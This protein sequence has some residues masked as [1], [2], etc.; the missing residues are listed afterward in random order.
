MSVEFEVKKF[1]LQSLLEKAFMVV[2]TKDVMPILKNFLFR[3]EAPDKIVVISTD[4]ALTMVAQTTMAKVSSSAQVVFPGAKLLDIVRSAEDDV[5]F[6]KIDGQSAE[7]KCA[8]S[9]I[10]LRLM[11][12][13]EYPLIPDVDLVVFTEINRQEFL[14]AVSRVS[15]VAPSDTYRPQLNMISLANGKVQASDGVRFHQADVPYP[16]KLQIPAKAMTDLVKFLK[17]TEDE[18][19]R[20]GE[21]P[22]HV[23]FKFGTEIFIALKPNVDFPPL[24]VELLQPAILTNDQCCT[25]D[26]QQLID[27]IRRVRVAADTETNLVHIDLK[28]SSMTLRARDRNGNYAT[29]DMEVVWSY[30]YRQLGVNW[31]L[32]L[33]TLHA[34]VSPTVSFYLGMD[35]KAKLSSLLI[36][37]TGFMAVL[38]QMRVKE[39][40]QQKAVK[41]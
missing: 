2:P 8:K 29:Q 21:T 14:A 23:V 20:L 38:S 4:Q 33:T 18:F 34:I 16:G 35:T 9:V 32:L 27:G 7:I 22:N 41:I 28:G 1:V 24:D 30:G 37:E 39:E 15:S 19:V 25:V 12:S 17:A 5:M 3:L 40:K 13:K 36:K 6:F 26:R 10:G 31:S 11:D